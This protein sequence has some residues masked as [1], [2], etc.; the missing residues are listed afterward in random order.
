[1]KNILHFLLKSIAFSVIFCVILG[2]TTG[3]LYNMSKSATDREDAQA[4]ADRA[5]AR[6]KQQEKTAKQDAQYEKEVAK[7]NENQKR[8]DEQMSRSDA[9]MERMEAFLKRDEAW[10]TQKEV[11]VKKEAAIL[12]E[13][14]RRLGLAKGK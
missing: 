13:Q 10:L 11:N 8:A 4:Q 12:A 2:A 7:W 14:E 6:Q 1:M 3:I 5:V 9:Q